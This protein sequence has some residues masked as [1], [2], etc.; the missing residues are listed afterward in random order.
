MTWSSLVVAKVASSEKKD[1]YKHAM[2]ILWGQWAVMSFSLIDAAIAGQFSTD[3]LAALAVGS[4]IY[5]T[6]YVTL[7]AVL[8]VTLPM[9]S[10][11]LGKKNFRQLKQITLQSLWVWALLSLLGFFCLKFPNLLMDL[12]SV[13]HESRAL[14]NGYLD[15][16]AWNLPIVLLFRLFSSLAQSLGV[17]RLVSSIQVTA[18]I[19]KIPLTLWLTFGGMGLDPMGLEG[20]AV[21][22]L[23]IQ[24]MMTTI[25]AVFFVNHEAFNGLR[26]YPSNQIYNWKTISQILAL[27]IPNGMTSAVE[28]SSFTLMGLFIA[29]LGPHATASHQIAASFAAFSFMAPMAFAVAT[30]ARLSYWLGAGNMQKA[31][32]VISAGYQWVLKLGLAFAALLLVSSHGLAGLF[33]NDQEVSKLAAQLMMVVGVFH[34]GDGLQILGFFLLRSFRIT[35]RPFLIYTATLWGLGLVGGYVL[36]Y[37]DWFLPSMKSP[38]AFWYC[39]ATAMM[40]SG[41]WLRVLLLRILDQATHGEDKRKSRA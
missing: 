21:S 40:I 9:F 19:I 28:V 15:V 29:R 2:T 20:C 17:P 23:L 18:L 4:S 7:M 13:P 41:V 10:E 39:S 16:M 26:L 34:V 32:E 31:Q 5:I 22:T 12:T 24:A 36:A 1:I 3:S 35:W 30:S 25:A 37:V 11:Q 33:S 8:Q 27:G 6:I 38:I 14:S